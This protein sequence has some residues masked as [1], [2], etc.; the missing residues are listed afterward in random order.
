MAINV[1][2]GWPQFV[3]AQ[4]MPIEAR[5]ENWLMAKISTLEGEEVI[6]SQK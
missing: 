2:F 4:I 6:I 1:F 5:Y 3:H